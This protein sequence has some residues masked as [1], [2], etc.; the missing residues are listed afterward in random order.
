VFAHGCSKQNWL[1]VGT[2]QFE[3]A[4]VRLPK[5]QLASVSES[6]KPLA[7]GDGITGT[8]QEGDGVVVTT[9]SGSYRFAYQGARQET[10]GQP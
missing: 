7:E 4:T 1:T 10:K 9:G 8:S 3:G 5:A 6:G 2:A